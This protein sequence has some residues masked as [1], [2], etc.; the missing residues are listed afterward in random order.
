MGKLDGTSTNGTGVD[1]LASLNFGAQ[2]YLQLTG[3]IGTS[4]VIK[5]QDSADNVTFADV[6]GLAFSSV[7]ASPNFQRIA[8]ANTA[9]IRQYVRAV[10]TGTFTAVSYNVVLVKN[11]IAGQIF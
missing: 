6:T 10:S 4:V 8:T 11:Q 3:F 9:T 1:T 7:T 5:I 2:A